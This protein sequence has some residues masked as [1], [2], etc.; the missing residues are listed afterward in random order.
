MPKLQSITF[1]RTPGKIPGARAGDLTTLDLDNPPGPLKDWRIIVRGG[2]V[3]LVSPRGWKPGQTHPRERDPNGTH[4]VHEIPR[5][6]VFLHWQATD[7]ADI[8]AILKGGKAYESEPLGPK[9]VPVAE[10]ALLPPLA[11]NEIGDA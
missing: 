10:S 4:V 6:D 11:P 1:D 9:Q 7:D 2:A 8:E 3:F 5:T